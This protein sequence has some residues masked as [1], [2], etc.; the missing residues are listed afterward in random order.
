MKGKW[1]IQRRR[2]ADRRS[3]TKTLAR[4]PG[5]VVEDGGDVL[6]HARM[7]GMCISVQAA[8]TMR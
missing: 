6:L 1:D 8:V 4:Q 3:E 2:V 7:R 5:C